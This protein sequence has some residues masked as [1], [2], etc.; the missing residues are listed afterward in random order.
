MDPPADGP[1]EDRLAVLLVGA[2]GLL[3]RSEL[4]DMLELVRAGEPG[5]ALEN[6]CVQMIEHDVVMPSEIS[7]ELRALA[8]AMGMRSVAGLP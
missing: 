1:I 2:A 5:V 8:K 7:T 6:F 4:E 3:P